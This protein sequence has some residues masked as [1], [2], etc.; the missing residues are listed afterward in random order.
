MSDSN[1]GLETVLARADRLLDRL[2]HWL[3]TPTAAP[4]WTASTA[5]RWRR[6]LQRGNL[7]P[8]QH[9]HGLKPEQLRNVDRQL[10]LLDRNTR[11]FLN[12]LPANNALLWGSRGTG[13]SSLVKA[14]LTSHAPDGLRLI[15]VDK[16]DLVDLPDILDL[17]WGRPERFILF[18]DDLSFE[19]DAG[20]YK[21]L[22]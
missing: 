2:E 6:R 4:D 8:V 3:P 9:P 19:A 14:M 10:E 11:Q 17:V 13:K 5:F 1:K 18:C 16:D 7:E 12:G 21:A 22:K 20:S 15:Q